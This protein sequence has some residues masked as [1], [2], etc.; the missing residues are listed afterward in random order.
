[1]VAT[2]A[3]QSLETRRERGMARWR[4]RSRLIHRLRV[5]LPSVMAA[6]LA[7]LTGWVVLGGLIERLGEGRG[8]GHAL[9]HMTNARF[10]G[11]DSA[12]RPYVLGAAEASRD[13]KD[14]NRIALIKPSLVLDPGGER[15]ARVTAD[16]GVYREDDRI[17][18]LEGNVTLRTADGVFT[19]ARAVVDTIQ[20]VVTGPDPVAGQGPMGSIRAQ[21]FGVYDR[22]ARV[23]FR[24]EV[25]SV[26]KRD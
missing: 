26:M 3:G 13:D 21:S 25:H 17:V 16:R 15:S 9:I 10:F 2:A 14:L 19:T 24:G 20:G 22:G 1:M 4:A 6:I 7:L 11:R 5:I 12:G 23:V 18:R 8:G